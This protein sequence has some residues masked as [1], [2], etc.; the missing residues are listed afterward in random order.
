MNKLGRILDEMTEIGA[1]IA[2]YESQL[3]FLKQR[4]AEAEEK[5]FAVQ[6]EESVCSQLNELL[7]SEQI[8]VS[9]YMELVVTAEANDLYALF[10]FLTDI[11]SVEY[12]DWLVDVFAIWKRDNA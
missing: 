6:A 2:Y 10:D 7:N 5:M 8:P 4:Y 11:N 3:S 9:S 12:V 1:N